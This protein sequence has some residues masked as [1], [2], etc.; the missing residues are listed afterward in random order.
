[1]R[2]YLDM[3]DISLLEI[4][5][6]NLDKVARQWCS[7]LQEPILLFKREVYHDS[8]IQKSSV[9]YRLY[10]TSHMDKHHLLIKTFNTLDAF[11]LW[12][13]SRHPYRGF[14][15]LNYMNCTRI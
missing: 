15:L 9:T 4:E 3:A 1:M 13:V 2:K 5:N 7:Q 14:E 10:L 12:Y 11:C 8:H 6:L